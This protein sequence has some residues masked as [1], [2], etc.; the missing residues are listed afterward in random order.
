MT[1]LYFSK[2]MN[3]PVGEAFVSS[4]DNPTPTASFKGLQASPY[5]NILIPI[6]P[7]SFPPF[8]HKHMFCFIPR[9]KRSLISSRSQLFLLNTYTLFCVRI[10]KW[11]F[12]NHANTLTFFPLEMFCLRISW[13]G[14]DGVDRT[15]YQKFLFIFLPLRY[16]KHYHTKYRT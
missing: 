11:H 16:I 10:R 1:Y 14:W 4:S 3:P 13:M 9:R 15:G 5:Q 6:V 8:L 7:L 2:E 12:Q